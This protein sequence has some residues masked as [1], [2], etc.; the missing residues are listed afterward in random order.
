MRP[1]AQI[2][3]TVVSSLARRLRPLL[4]GLLLAGAAALPGAPGL[5]REPFATPDT[6]R[7]YPP[8]R[9]YDLEHLRLELSFDW[10]KRSVAGTATNTLV[11]LLP[12]LDHLIFHAVELRVER[13]RLA[14]KELPF[15]LD[16]EAGTLTVR[17]DHP[18]GPQDRLEVAID[19][20]AQPRAGLYFVGPDRAYADKSP[21]IWSQGEPDLNRR[22]FP[23]WDYPDDRATSELL[24]TVA[25][26]FQAIGNG[27]LVEVLERP[28]GRRTYHWKMEQPHST[29]LVSVVVGEFTRIADTANGVPIE[30]YVPPHTPAGWARRSFGRTP[31]MIDYFARSTGIP[32]PFAKYAQ[33]AVYDYMWGGME[34]ISATTQTARTLHDERAEQ[35]NPSEGLVSH[36]A[37]HQW[38]GDLITCDSWDHVWL[39][40]GM[41]NYFEAL[42]RGHAGGADEL[43]QKIDEYR[44]SYFAEDRDEYRR[45]IVTNRYSDPIALF[46]RHTYEKGALVLHMVHYLLGEE[47]WWKGLHDYAQRYANRTVTTA[48]LQSALEHSTGVSLGALFDQYVY[49]AGYPELAVRWDYQPETGMVHLEVR[50]KQKLDAETGL[51]SFPLEVA[52]VG[53]AGTT[54]HRV[55]LL[56]R[57]LQDLYVPSPAR[58]QT[59]IL[60]PQGWILATVDFDK[61][62]SEWVLQLASGAPVAARLAAA[63]ALGQSSATAPPEVVAALARALRE[64][65]FWGVRAA[66]AKALGEIGGDPALA[67]L[68]TGLGDRASKVRTAV[69]EAF[70]KFPRHPE[71]V[72]RL[73]G[74]LERDESYAARAAAAAS[75]G[76]FQDRRDEVVPVLVKALA[77]P[78]HREQVRAAAIKALA[79]LDARET[80]DEAVRLARYGA[81]AESRK[82]ALLAL[83]QLAAKRQ[84]PKFTDKTRAVLES[85]LADPDYLLRNSAHGA[86]AALADPAAIPALEKSARS[87]ADAEQRESAEKAIREI[88]DRVAAAKG[89][90][91][92]RSRVQQLEREVDVLKGRLQE[93]ESKGKGARP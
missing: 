78:S 46:D 69:L 74:S 22:W 34:N 88:R 12:G 76:K 73:R 9:Q 81:P 17:L 18:Y 53:D 4:L 36:E 16:P 51:F 60:D 50:Q 13:V 64:E 75:L 21:Q 57:P 47:G 84:D 38:F 6:P 19:Y 2:S 91:D 92:L 48:D 86:L 1:K 66:A 30:Y 5:A 56:A 14:G 62:W 43:A 61:P 55:P 58:P 85:Y 15:T 35:D 27:R 80:W 41:A 32:Y 8:A 45:P 52:L 28:D 49:G 77:Q 40:E 29:Y 67:A 20:S 10:E 24:A 39:N 89:D 54:V 90:E 37:A 26:P 11:P 3:W 68:A 71:L 63:R 44:E 72:A 23:S 65:P 7:Q 93:A 70:G 79:D 31:D 33:S 42:Y 83:A 25:R 82:D 59:V 87:A